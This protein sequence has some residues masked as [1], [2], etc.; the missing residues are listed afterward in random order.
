MEPSACSVP[1]RHAQPRHA[2]IEWGQQSQ[3][4]PKF[5]SMHTALPQGKLTTAAL[6]GL[7]TP[8]LPADEQLA[9]VARAAGAHRVRRRGAGHLHARL[10]H[11]DGAGCGRGDRARAAARQKRLPRPQ[12]RLLPWLHACTAC[13]ARL[14]CAATTRPGSARSASADRMEVNAA[15][16]AARLG[17]GWREL[18]RR[19]WSRDRGPHL[20]PR[21]AG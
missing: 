2:L 19:V 15:Q 13:A 6:R 18:V 9:A 12:L 8:D 11:G 5:G 1:C 17:V 4:K 20:P 7:P 16:G 10:D 21:R 14:H 3:Q